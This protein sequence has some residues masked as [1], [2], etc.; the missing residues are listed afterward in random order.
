MCWDRIVEQEC[1]LFTPK[2]QPASFRQHH[3]TPR[4]LTDTTQPVHHQLVAVEDPALV[5][6]A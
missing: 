1:D 6:V 3:E 5:L 2:Q 4:R